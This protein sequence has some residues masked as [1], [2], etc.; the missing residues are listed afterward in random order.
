MRLICAG[1]LCQTSA[2]PEGGD[3]FCSFQ[4]PTGSRAWVEQPALA[5]ISDSHIAQLL[6]HRENPFVFT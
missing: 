2:Q 1:S 6:F 4:I 5:E 3:G